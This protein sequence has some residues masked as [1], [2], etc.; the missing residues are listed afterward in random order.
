[1]HARCLVDEALAWLTTRGETRPVLL[2][3]DD[4]T[5]AKS[6][7]QCQL[8]FRFFEVYSSTLK[9]NARRI[10]KALQVRYMHLALGLRLWRGPDKGPKYDTPKDV[11]K[12]HKVFITCSPLVAKKLAERQ[13]K[14]NF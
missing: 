9:I 3:H 7:A 8:G 14:V 5:I 4:K 2:W 1:M 12:V 11:G 13:I 6:D 10:E